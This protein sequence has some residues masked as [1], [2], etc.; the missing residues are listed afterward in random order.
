MKY[1]CEVETSSAFADYGGRSIRVCDEWHSYEKFRSWVLQS[2]YSDRLSIDRINVNKN[3]EPD[4]CRWADKGLQANNRRSNVVLE[5]NSIKHTVAEW[6][7]DCRNQP[8]YH[9]EQTK[10]RLVC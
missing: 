2:G 3:Y 4:N 6:G 5:Y 10:T 1:R 9:T 8:V 7:K